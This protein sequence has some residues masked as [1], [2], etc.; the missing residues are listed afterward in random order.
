MVIAGV[1][2]GVLCST[3]PRNTP[4]H[5]AASTRD[6]NCKV[7]LLPQVALG[8]RRG[9][10]GSSTL[11]SLTDLP[12]P[13][14]SANVWLASISDPHGSTVSI[15]E[16]STILGSGELLS[17]RDSSLS[18]TQLE[19]HVDGAH[20]TVVPL[21]QQSP[22]IIR[23]QQTINLQLGRPAKLQNNDVLNLVEDKYAYRV[24]I[25]EDETKTHVVNSR[26]S[27][28]RVRKSV[29]EKTDFDSSSLS[30]TEA[31]RNFPKKK[32]KYLLK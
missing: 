6:R 4:I 31:F 13:V 22:R 11:I 3:L 7:T 27:S 30:E 29:K 26:R 25:D 32:Q 16:G 1:D 28:T 2:L 19:I 15:H 20:V 10:L 18:T 9:G 24:T 14:R 8:S 12:R 5:L 21:T 17:L 23:G